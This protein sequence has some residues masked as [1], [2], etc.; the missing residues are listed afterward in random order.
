MTT[1]LHQLFDIIRPQVEAAFWASFAMSGY[2][3]QHLL[4]PPIGE[5]VEAWEDAKKRAWN[6][7]NDKSE[8]LF[9]KHDVWNHPEYNFGNDDQNGVECPF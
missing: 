4:Q 2:E 1:P 8:Q 3:R 6:A 9:E 5:A 7:A